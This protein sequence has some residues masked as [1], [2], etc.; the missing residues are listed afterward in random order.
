VR[1]WHPGTLRT[2][3]REHDDEGDS[4]SMVTVVVVFFE[5]KN[6]KRNTDGDDP[7]SVL[8]PHKDVGWGKGSR[9]WK[10]LSR[11][12]WGICERI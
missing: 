2:P 8:T 4:S 12:S 1:K 9:Y 7:S 5:I 10:N 3:Y 6:L 11:L